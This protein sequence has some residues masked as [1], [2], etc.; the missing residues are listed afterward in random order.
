MTTSSTT[1]PESA[2]RRARA[3]CSACH[4]ASTL[5]RVAIRSASLVRS[6]RAKGGRQVSSSNSRRRPCASCSPPGRAGSGFDVDGRFVEQLGHDAP[7]QGVDGRHLG[8]IEAG[9]AV[10]K[11]AQL[12][13]ADGL[14]PL[15]QG[16][17]QGCHL[18][19]GRP[20]EIALDLLGDDGLR[21]RG[22]P[23]GARPWRPRPRPSGRPCRA[24]SR[25][26]TIPTAGSTSRGTAMST[27]SSG[28]PCRWSRTDSRSAAT[29]ST[30]GEPVEAR[31]TSASTRAL[32]RADHS[33]AR[34][35]QRAASWV[36]RLHVRLT[37]SSEPA[38]SAP[39]RAWAMLSPISPAPST[40]VVLP[41]SDP[42]LAVATATAAWESEVV[43]RAMAV[44][45][46]TRLPTSRAWRNSADSTGPAVWLRPGRLPGVADLAE[47]LALPEDGRVQPGGHLEQVGGGHLVVVRVQLVGEQLGRGAAPLREE[48]ADLAHGRVEA[49]GVGVD[50][51]AQAGRDDDH[52]AQVVPAGQ[53]VQRLRPP[54]R[55]APSSASSSRSGVVRWLSPTT[56][57][58]TPGG[59]PLPGPCGRIG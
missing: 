45:E 51:G 12:P 37:T 58:D 23:G 22:L 9:Q 30:S 46:R 48:V 24:A 16:R 19:L 43:P 59:A 34:P 36:A 3:T 14:A 41:D 52:L 55:A 27:M 20:V 53:V 29:S 35:P 25:P 28:R 40:R 26:A 47:D 5:P 57:T 54:G 17:D 44:S 42:S 49:S 50:L 38:S 4:R 1:S 31:R 32:G 56:T 18:T 33:M 10:A 6:G 11:T 2:D 8:R 39:A 13:G 7:G 21:P 15:V